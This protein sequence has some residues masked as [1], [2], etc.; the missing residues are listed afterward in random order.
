[1]I[2]TA[3]GM[4]SIGMISIKKFPTSLIWCNLTTPMQSRMNNNIMPYM[5]PGIGRGIK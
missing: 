3:D 2:P 4:K 5:L 1:M